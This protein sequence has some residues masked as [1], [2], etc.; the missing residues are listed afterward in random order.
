MSAIGIFIHKAWARWTGIVV[1]MIGALI[2]LLVITGGL[3]P[4]EDVGMTVFGVI[5]VAT[6]VLVLV[7]LALGGGHFE[8]RP[9]YPGF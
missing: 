6:H 3:A 9:R 2:G 1:G 7:G 5:W 4:P 8:A